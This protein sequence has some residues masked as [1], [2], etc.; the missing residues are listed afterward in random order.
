[1][2][3]AVMLYSYHKNLQVCSVGFVMYPV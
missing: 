2:A 1:M 3:G